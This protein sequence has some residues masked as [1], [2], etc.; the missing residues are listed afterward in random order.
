MQEG[1]AMTSADVFDQESRTSLKELATWVREIAQLTKPDGIV[2]CDGSQQEWERLTGE[3]VASGTLNRLNPEL[4]PNSFYCRSDPGDVARVESRTFICSEREA[5]AG[6]TNN[7]LARGDAPDV[8]PDLRRLHARPHHVRGPV[9][10]GP[11]RLAI[12]PLGVEITDSPYVVVSMRIMTRMGKP[13][14]R[15][16]EERGFFVQAVHSVG[17]PLQPGQQ[18]VPWPCN[19]IKY[20]SHF[21]ETGRSGPTAPATAATPCWARSA[22]RCASPR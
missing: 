7:W 3:L 11:A 1:I 10:H 2:W 21:P 20:I 5:D 6:P 4:R 14:L 18:D 15:V 13:A 12:S 8:R 22:T 19:E 9:L 16:I 17:A